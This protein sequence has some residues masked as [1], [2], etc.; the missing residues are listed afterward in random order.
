MTRAPW[1][2]RGGDDPLAARR[3]AADHAD[4][5]RGRTSDRLASRTGVPL[6]VV[7][8]TLDGLSA[9]DAY[10]DLLSD[11]EL[12]LAADRAGID[13][14][15]VDP[16]TMEELRGYL[17][18]L[19]GAAGE[20]A[21]VSLL[22]TGA[23]PAPAGADI[24]TLEPFTTPGV[25]L[26]FVGPGLDTAANVKIA[27]DADVILAHFARYASQ[28][29]IVYASSDAAADAAERG[30]RVIAAGDALDLA[31]GPVVVDMGVASDTFDNEIIPY[32]DGSHVEDGLDLLPDI[33]WFSVGMIA[34]RGIA[35]IRAGASAAEAARQAGN[36]AVRAGVTLA[37][38]KTASIVGLP[39][40]ATAA[41]AITA[42]MAASAALEV[43]RS[44]RAAA[45]RDS[46]LGALADAFVARWA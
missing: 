24:V 41:A 10:G 39:D 6:V 38:G 37:A 26:H 8:A 12:A 22:T 13:L 9:Q 46:Q 11:Q 31:A 35:R 14:A 36:D 5:L 29:P 7:A 17:S 43:R 21:V 33:P 34:V 32:L 19:R 27:A 1:V 16:S 20:H 44:W 2:L 30:L 40:P 3:V 23:L 45:L 15:S 4:H 18:A 42:G 28:V 25:D